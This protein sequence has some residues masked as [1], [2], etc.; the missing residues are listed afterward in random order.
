MNYLS[1]TYSS[2]TGNGGRLGVISKGRRKISAV[3]NCKANHVKLNSISSLMLSV[4]AHI[5]KVNKKGLV[6]QLF[7]DIYRQQGDLLSPSIP[8]R[9]KTNTGSRVHSH[10]LGII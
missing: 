8:G 2:N 4:M 6:S 10:S 1:C 7:F 5:I 9:N 3:N